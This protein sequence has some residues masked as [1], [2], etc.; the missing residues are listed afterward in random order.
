M[1]CAIRQRLRE[2]A[3]THLL[4]VIRADAALTVCHLINLQTQAALKEKQAF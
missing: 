1:G 4:I 3:K 2:G